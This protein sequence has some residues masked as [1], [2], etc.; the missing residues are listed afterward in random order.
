MVGLNFSWCRIPGNIWILLLKKVLSSHVS[1]VF[2]CKFISAL[3]WHSVTVH[4]F[5]LLLS[6]CHSL[7]NLS[8]EAEHVTAQSWSYQRMPAFTPLPPAEARAVMADLSL[9]SGQLL[10]S[11]IS[12]RFAPITVFEKIHIGL[13]FRQISNGSSLNLACS[14]QIWFFT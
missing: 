10:P 7:L 6:S 13:E 9:S 14:S 3:I 8:S 12:C 1:F 5:C 2:S 11:L 4:T